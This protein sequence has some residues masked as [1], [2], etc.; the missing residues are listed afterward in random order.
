MD[1]ITKVILN[2][3]VRTGSNVVK[4][5]ITAQLG[6][7]IGGLAGTVIDTVAGNLGVTPDQIPSFSPSDI[8][9]AVAMAEDNPEILRLYVEQQRM[10]NTL[11]LA[12]MQKDEGLWTWAWRPAWMWFLLFLWAW[13]AVILPLVVGAF[14]ASIPLIP[15]EYL[16]GVTAVY[17]TFYLGGHTVKSAMKDYV[18]K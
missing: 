10:T 9:Q 2:A 7:T 18:K 3:A 12:E 1:N 17:T 15:Y 6:S 11:L 16:A 8:D 14:G 5:I 4:D 13:N